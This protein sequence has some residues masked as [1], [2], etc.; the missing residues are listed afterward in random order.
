MELIKVIKSEENSDIIGE[1]QK[2]EMKKNKDNNI[3]SSEFEK[4]VGF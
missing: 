3:N 1:F 2:L 4:A